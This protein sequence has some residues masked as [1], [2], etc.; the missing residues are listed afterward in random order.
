M[1]H[2]V[3]L[4]INSGSVHLKGSDFVI[5]QDSSLEK[6]ISASTFNDLQSAIHDLG[7][8]SLLS[9]NTNY[10]YTESEAELVSYQVIVHTGNVRG[11]GTDASIFINIFGENVCTCPYTLIT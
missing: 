6:N 1:A 2:A 4:A 5:H 11:A 10:R 3:P 7:R 8:H 9:A